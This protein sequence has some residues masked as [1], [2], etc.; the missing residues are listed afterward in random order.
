MDAKFLKET[1][2][3]LEERKTTLEKG[4]FRICEER[5]KYGRRLGY[6]ISFV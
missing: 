4:L 2:K 5:Q 3:K 1:K 6:K